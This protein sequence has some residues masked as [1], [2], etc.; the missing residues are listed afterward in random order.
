MSLGEEFRLLSEVP[1][2]QGLDQR[3]LKL[4]SFV[5]QRLSFEPGQA[6]CRQGD[7][8]DAVYVVV[9]GEVDVRLRS[10]GEE[11]HLRRVGR[12]AIIGE[13]GTL[14][15]G[16]RTASVIAHT[17]VVALKLEQAHFHRLLQDVPA[18]KEAVERHIEKADYT[19]E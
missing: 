6:L 14:A 16:Q 2:L 5:C 4:L 11:R 8:A 9:D 1:P 7:V 13:V 12:H 17:P 18:L 19:Y 3:R 10:G 15:I